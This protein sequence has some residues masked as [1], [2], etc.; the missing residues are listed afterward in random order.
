[1]N[2]VLL[3]HADAKVGKSWLAAST[4]TP[5]LIIDAEGG[6]RFIPW[7]KRVI[8]DPRNPPPEV[9]DSW[10]TAIVYARDF[11]AVRKVMAF[12]VSG[13]HPFKS[14]SVDSITTVQKRLIAQLYGTEQPTQ[15]DWGDVLRRMEELVGALRDLAIHP[16]HPLECVVLTAL[17]VLQDGKIRPMVKG[18]LAMTLPGF[19]DVVGYLYIDVDQDTGTPHRKLAIQPVQAHWLAGDR[20]HTLT[21]KLGPVVTNPK[22]TKMLAAFNGVEDPTRE[23]N[24]EATTEAA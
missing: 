14:V 6:S 10:D 16:T 22:L 9:S 23:D 18:Q 21:Q 11:E 13:K 2:L 5:R 19:P 15:A 24:S 20:T 4:P 8:W 12:L 17:S 1:M 3:A 7:P